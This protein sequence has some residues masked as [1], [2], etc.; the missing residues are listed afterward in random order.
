MRFFLEGEPEELAE[1]AD[2]VLGELIKAFSGIAPDF[3]ER[4]HKALPEAKPVELRLPVLRELH[5]KTREAYAE[6]LKLMLKDIG[7][8]LDGGVEKGFYDYSK[9]IADAQA[10]GYQR[11]KGALKRQG[12]DDR[13]FEEGGSLYG[14]ST[15]ELIELFRARQVDEP[16][17]IQK[18]SA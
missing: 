11:V 2:L 1:K 15:N 3:V 13:D 7:A 4:L 10:L 9:P 8:V 12:F 16:D 6:Q 18:T 17:E 14:M 5:D